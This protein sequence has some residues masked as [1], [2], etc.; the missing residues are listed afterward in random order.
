MGAIFWRQRERE[1][2]LKEA[3][4]IVEQAASEAKKK[5]HERTRFERMERKRQHRQ[6]RKRKR[7][8]QTDRSEAYE[9]HQADEEVAKQLHEGRKQREEGTE[10]EDQRQQ[11]SCTEG[12]AEG[13]SAGAGGSQGS[14]G[15]TQSTGQLVPKSTSP[16]SVAEGRPARNG[17][18]QSSH[19][20]GCSLP[21]GRRK[22]SSDAAEDTAQ[23]DEDVTEHVGEAE[24]KSIE[25]KAP[26]EEQCK[27]TDARKLDRES[28][29]QVEKERW[30][31][32]H[33]EEVTG[34]VSVAPNARRSGCSTAPEME[35]QCNPIKS[36]DLAN[37]KWSATH[38][39]HKAR[40]D[41]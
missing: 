20:H 29:T 1:Q 17:R 18:R 25:P 12:S 3:A 34:E 14:R 6:Y 37:G 23:R 22:K 21:K 16:Q 36:R 33:P 24:D 28:C 2:Y 40:C 41:T 7:A 10:E 9:T 5:A 8:E 13:R 30:S 26:G 31:A 27:D 32:T 38:C 19:Q 11:E 35:G 39:E 15:G 4:R